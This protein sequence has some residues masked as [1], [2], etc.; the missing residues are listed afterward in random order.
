MKTVCGM[1]IFPRTRLLELQAQGLS[2]YGLAGGRI[3]IV[4]CAVRATASRSVVMDALPGRSVAV[5]PLAGTG[6]T[7]MVPTK[8]GHCL[9]KVT[10]CR[11]HHTQTLYPPSAA[12][13][14]GRRRDRQQ[15][16]ANN[17]HCP[18]MV[19]VV[20]V[21]CSFLA[22]SSSAVSQCRR[23]HVFT[24]ILQIVSRVQGCREVSYP[25]WTKRFLLAVGCTYAKTLLELCL[26]QVGRKSPL[27][28]TYTCLATMNLSRLES[29]PTVVYYSR[30]VLVAASSPQ[31]RH[32][33]L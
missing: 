26:A 9:A 22:P 32:A 14:R 25:E 19:C 28:S 16:S 12:A 31:T 4:G 33:D 7:L 5:F 2:K 15:M 24:S 27:V 13:K 8:R 17:G 23:T 20:R 18:K 1:Q 30:T 10:I 21:V 29:R 6:N 3:S 11:R